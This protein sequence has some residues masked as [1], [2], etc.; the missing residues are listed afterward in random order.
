[1]E[2]T[3]IMESV[4]DEKLL[5]NLQYIAYKAEIEDIFEWTNNNEYLQF[6]A[7]KINEIYQSRDALKM[8]V[9]STMLETF[10]FYSGFFTPLYYLGNNKLANV[11][12]N[13]QVNHS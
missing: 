9:A 5:N 3:S 4:H 8:K 10:L 6:K 7:R 11:A 12:E 1:M 13:Y 2:L